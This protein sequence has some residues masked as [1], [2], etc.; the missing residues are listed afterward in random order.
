[1]PTPEDN[2]L[3]RMDGWPGGVNNRVRETEQSVSRDGEK[4]P[5]SQFLRQALNVDLTAEGHPIRRRGYTV[6]TAGYSHSA[7]GCEPLGVF[8]VVVEGQLLAG[9]DPDNLS[10][11][12]AVNRYNR[13]SYCYV[14]DTIYYSNGQQ[15]GEIGY[16]YIHRAWGIPVGQTPTASSSG[17][18][19][20]WAEERQV[21]VTYEDA[22]GREGGA[23]EP[24]LVQSSAGGSVTVTL[25]MPLP[26][27]V[28]RA[29][30][31]VSQ[32]NSEI[33]YLA[34]TVFTVPTTTIYPQNIGTGRELETLNMKPPKAGQLVAE[35]NGRVYIAR[36]DQV[37]FTEALKYHLTRPAI[38]IYMMPDYITLLEP[39][40]D[41]VYVGTKR[42]VVFLSGSDPYVV[43]QK[44]VSSYAPV[45]YAVSRMSGEKFGVQVDEVP[46]WWGTDGV[47]VVGLPGGE[48]R[49]LTRD[50]LA[51]P[52]F[53]MGAVGLREYEGMSHVVSTLNRGDGI[54]NMGATDTVVATVRQNN[55][56]LNS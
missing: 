41:G 50:R 46:V 53:E 3:L 47:M 27:D 35:M 7:W 23:S 2:Q 4:I 19:T 30:I 45:E 40:T 12:A 37:T 22:Y 52:E 21:A 54:N 16:D 6:H 48:L 38:G 24:I 31:Y 11:V 51:V 20:S 18:P 32:L 13:V 49:Q 36:N 14:N 25:T 10:V 44:Y 1:M 8:C 39:S 17:D 15:L 43:Q 34:Q 33:L 56:V 28:V 55:I 26:A 29:N 9:P 5:S 42:G